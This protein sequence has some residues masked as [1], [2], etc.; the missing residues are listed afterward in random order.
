MATPTFTLLNHQLL[1]SADNNTGWND[2]TT[3]DPDIKVEGTNSMS[4]IFRADGEQGYYD[5]G[6]APVSAAGKTVRGWILSNSIAYMG[7]EAVDGYKLLMYDGTNTELKTIFGSDTYPGGWFNYIWDCDD[8]TTLTLANVQRWGVEA[9]HAT[10]ARNVTNTW[11]DAIRYLDGYS[12]TGGTSG[13]PVRLADIA[14][15]DK[16]DALWICSEFQGVYFA[17]GTIQFGTGATAHH[18]VMDGQVLVFTEQSVAAGLY[19]LSGVGSGTNITIVSSVLRSTGVGDNTRFIVDFSDAT[20]ASCVFTDNL[21][22]RASTVDFASGVDARNNV[23]DDCGQISPQGADMRGSSV[24][25]YEGTANTS[26]LIYDETADP[27]GEF[28]DMSFT[29]GTAATHAI[30]FGLNS[31]TAITLR[32]IDFSGYNVNNNQNDSTLHVLRTSGTVTISLVGC[33][34]NISYRTEGATVVLVQD[35]VTT[36][37]TVQDINTG[38]PVQNARVYMIAASG[39]P[40]AQGTVIIQGLTDVNGQISDTRTLASAQPITG[41]VR[42]ATTGTLYKQGPIAGTISNVAGL[43]LTVQMIP[44]E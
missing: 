8:F 41:W 24:L 28:D 15:T 11:M 44:D 30:E 16:V 20:L 35:P 27:D 23:F 12:M 5:A 32:G 19:S 22:V 33:T 9:G 43:A 37:V 1:T 13:D 26:A 14:A 6:T 29:K 21:V 39:G 10:N 31:P 18:F 25:N 38:S 42:R 36:T 7:T 2:L 3:A 40:L 34:G 17:T 4:G